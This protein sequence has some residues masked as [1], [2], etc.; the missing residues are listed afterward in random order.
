MNDCDGDSVD[1]I[2][3]ISGLKE[4]F[5]AAVRKFLDILFRLIMTVTQSDRDITIK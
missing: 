2:K 1:K 5:L 4:Y 3:L